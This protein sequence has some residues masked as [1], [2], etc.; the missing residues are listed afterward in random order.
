MGEAFKRETKHLKLPNIIFFSSILLV[1]KGYLGMCKMQNDQP[2]IKHILFLSKQR[3]QEKFD[4][5]DEQG[6]KQPEAKK[7]K[8][9]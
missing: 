4:K 1:T 5:S 6:N 9:R 2:N 8:N 7:Q 3:I